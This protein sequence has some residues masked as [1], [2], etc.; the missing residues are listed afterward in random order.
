MFEMQSSLWTQEERRPSVR[1]S[2]K[3]EDAWL[4]TI[5][6]YQESIDQQPEDIS[7]SQ[8]LKENTLQIDTHRDCF[9]GCLKKTVEFQNDPRGSR[10]FGEVRQGRNRRIQRGGREG[11]PLAG[12]PV[13]RWFPGDEVEDLY[14]L[15][16]RKMEKV[17]SWVASW[18]MFFW[19][20][21]E[22]GCDRMKVQRSRSIV[23]VHEQI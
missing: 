2:Q 21:R 23:G 15:S 9:P 18:W 10:A 12:G 5:W 17:G 7:N 3:M 13:M 20:M 19:R 22:T 8:I 11:V 4:S 1:N 14:D 16:P 6:W